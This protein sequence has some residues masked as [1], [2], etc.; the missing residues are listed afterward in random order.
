MTEIKNC[1]DLAARLDDLINYIATG[2]ILDAMTEFYAENTVMEEPAYGATA[3]LA[4]NIEREKAFLA[5]VKEW[6]GFE[7]KGKSVG[8]NVTMYEH[9]MDWVDVNDNDVHVEQVAVAYWENG[10]IVHER[11]YYNMG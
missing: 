1:V 4:E 9:T 2:R 5:S 6:K 8:E 10:K 7:V 3:G 11:F